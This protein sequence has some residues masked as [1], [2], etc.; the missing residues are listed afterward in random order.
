LNRFAVRW[1]YSYI[2]AYEDDFL[3]ADRPV[4]ARGS[5]VD[6]FCVCIIMELCETDIQ[7]LI[8]V[9]CRARHSAR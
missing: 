1:C 4:R 7:G 3:C 2:V 5:S 9:R 8:E 6:W